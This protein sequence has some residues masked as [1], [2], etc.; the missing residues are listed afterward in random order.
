MKERANPGPHFLHPTNLLPG[1]IFAEQVTKWAKDC[2]TVVHRDQPHGMQNGS[3]G[4]MEDTQH[5]A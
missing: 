1:P 2:T 5:I 4:K 3:G